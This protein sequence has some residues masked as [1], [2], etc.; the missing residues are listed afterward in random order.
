MAQKVIKIGSSAAI[1]LPKR[2]LEKLGISIGDKVVVESEGGKIV[3]EP[4]KPASSRDAHIA[5]LTH[6]FVERYR[7]DLEALS[8][9]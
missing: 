6:N 2:I 8:D 5:K 9:K 7:E 4:Q 3:V 1:T